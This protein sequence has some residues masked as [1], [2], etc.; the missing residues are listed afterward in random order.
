[1]ER[2]AACLLLALPAERL[3]HMP[4]S[5]TA[6]LPPR[7][8]SLRQT[9]EQSAI[10]FPALLSNRTGSSEAAVRELTFPRHKRAKE[11]MLC[12][13]GERLPRR[14]QPLKKRGLAGRLGCWKPEQD[15]FRVQTLR[16]LFRAQEPKKNSTR[17]VARKAARTVRSW[18][19][20]RLRLC[21][22]LSVR[23]AFWPLVFALLALLEP[24]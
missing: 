9:S 5:A 14:P 23:F 1:M 16:G 17:C 24:L 22:R 18:I 19:A 4:R 11:V 12:S 20:Y 6:A 10:W 7:R 2:R 8:S 13:T 21:P 3:T 15:R